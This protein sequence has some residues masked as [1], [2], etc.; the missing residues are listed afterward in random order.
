MNELPFL[1]LEGVVGSAWGRKVVEVEYLLG[2]RQPVRERG[3]EI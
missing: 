2:E 1:E 3:V